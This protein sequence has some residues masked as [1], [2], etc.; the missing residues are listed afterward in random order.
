MPRRPFIAGNWKMNMP[1]S[2]DAAVDLVAQSID[3]TR[4]ATPAVVICPPVTMISRLAGRG[5]RIGAQD[6][7]HAPSGA[8]TGDISASM[9]ASVGASHVIVG[10]S[11]R[12]AAYQESDKA[13]AAKTKAAWKAEL[14]A[15]V[16]V[17]ETL[18]QR[19]SGDA[20]SCV[21]AQVAGCLPKGTTTANTVIAYEPVWA[22][23]SGK[24]ASTEEISEMHKAIRAAVSARF[25]LEV[26]RG[27]RIVYGGSVTAAN[28]KEIFAVEDVDGG[29]IGGASLKAPEFI[30]IINSI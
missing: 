24:A 6:C 30:E 19:E 4:P 15:I 1:S 16:C 28:A 10:H 9:L 27:V 26:G 23:G 5:V 18:E 20:V 13:V 25:D 21:S 17:G 14:T 12:R 2:P 11:E 7:H 3:S 8:H 29:L 22:I